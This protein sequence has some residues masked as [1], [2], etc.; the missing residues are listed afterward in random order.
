[1]FQD[2]ADDQCINFE[3]S[4][5]STGSFSKPKI[6]KIWKVYRDSKTGLQYFYNRITKVT[7]WQRPDDVDAVT[8]KFENKKV[9]H[10]TCVKKKAFILSFSVLKVT[11][12][13]F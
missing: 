4:P 2:T 5:T 12:F 9:V 10:A 7:Q 13:T 1:M 8:G 3:E 11:I 6:K